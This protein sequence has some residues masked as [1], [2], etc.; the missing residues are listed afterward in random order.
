[1]QEM[2]A[3]IQSADIQR[4]GKALYVTL[5][6]SFGSS[7][8]GFRCEPSGLHDLLSTVGARYFSDLEGMNVRALKQ[9][10]WHGR[11]LGIKHITKDRKFSLAGDD[12]KR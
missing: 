8:Q 5:R 7:S 1:M 11:I 10:G 4:R 9:D 3:T 12:N 6:L 2:N